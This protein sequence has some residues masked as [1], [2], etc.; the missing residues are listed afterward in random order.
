M[1]FKLNWI[2]HWASADFAKGLESHLSLIFFPLIF[3]WM[4]FPHYI[5]LFTSNFEFFFFWKQKILFLTEFILFQSLPPSSLNLY[6]FLIVTIDSHW[7]AL[8]ISYYCTI[9][10]K[11]NEKNIYVSRLLIGAGIFIF[12]PLCSFLCFGAYFFSILWSTG[13]M[14]ND[15]WV[16]TASTHVATQHIEPPH[17]SVLLRS[18]WGL[19]RKSWEIRTLFLDETE[20]TFS[21]S[22]F[23]LLPA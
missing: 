4:S 14:G 21:C 6:L 1:K 2:H 22:C 18:N 12:C 15:L 13:Y 19:Q 11:K 10:M 23:S 5:Y 17:C 16:P 7:N 3:W 20:Q 9:V 8:N